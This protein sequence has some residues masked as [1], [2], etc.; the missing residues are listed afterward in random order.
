[1]GSAFSEHSRP[2]VSSC[3]VA[4]ED[5]LRLGVATEGCRLMDKGVDR[6]ARRCAI[7]Q[8]LDRVVRR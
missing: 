3:R 6:A 8:W 2:A 5:L 7:G 4:F 1:M